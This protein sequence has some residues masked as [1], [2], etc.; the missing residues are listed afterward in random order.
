MIRGLQAQGVPQST[1]D[2]LVTNFNDLANANLLSK[3]VWQ[4][5]LTGFDQFTTFAPYFYDWIDHPNYDAYWAKLDVETRYDDVKVPAL[6]VS[7]WYDIFQVGSFRNY[8]G[9]RS[10]GGTSDGAEGDQDHRRSVRTR[11]RQRE[12]HLWTGL[13]PPASRPRPSSASSTATSR[14][15]RTGTRTIP[16]SPSTCWFRRTRG[17]PAARSS[18]LAIAIRSRGPG[19]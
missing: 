8:A 14:G 9:M 6:N 17:R 2:Q 3:W 18:S 15:S 12:S 16:T 1:I 4:L 5:P 19:T 7:A 11:W 10:E 13:R